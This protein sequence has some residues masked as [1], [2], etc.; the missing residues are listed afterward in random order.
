MKIYKKAFLCTTVRT[1][2]SLYK[3]HTCMGLWRDRFTKKHFR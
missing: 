3:F 1:R 2:F